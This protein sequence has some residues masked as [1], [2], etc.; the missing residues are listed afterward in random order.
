MVENGSL[1]FSGGSKHS[2]TTCCVTLGLSKSQFPHLNIDMKI[3]SALNVHI[4][5]ANSHKGL[6]TEAATE[7]TLKISRCQLIY[8]LLT[9]LP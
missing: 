3:V 6:S 1:D 5:G 4:Q 8:K 2:P 7:S 9:I